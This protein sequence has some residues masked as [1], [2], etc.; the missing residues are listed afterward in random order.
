V[1]SPSAH[2]SL[3]GSAGSAAIM[4]LTSVDAAIMALTSVDAR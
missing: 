3:H 4:A 1:H 2:K